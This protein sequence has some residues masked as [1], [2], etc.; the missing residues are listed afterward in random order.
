MKNSTLFV[1]AF[2]FIAHQVV[3]A[4]ASGKDPLVPAL[5]V[6]GDST[7][8]PGNNNHL[9]TMS[10]GIRW[11]YGIDLNNV[12]GR[13]TNG[14]NVADFFATYLSLP[15]PP[16][17]LNLSDSERSQIKTGINYGSGA[18]GILNTTRVGECLSLAQQVKYFTIT[19]MKDLPK[20]LKTQKKV[21]EHL[22]KS[23]YFFSI[24][25]NDYHPEVNNNITSNFSSTGFADHLLDE[26]T[27]Y[28]KVH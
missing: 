10:Q 2:C 14:K 22:A 19:R 1:L 26:I 11:P 6:F 23:I 12:R 18:C 4:H 17:F 8:D 20:A 5:Y 3:F 13:H 24:G 15:M 27:K 7:V 16:P 9:N 28:I 21:R 25:I